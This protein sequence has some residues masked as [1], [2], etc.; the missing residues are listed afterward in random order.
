LHDQYK[1]RRAEGESDGKKLRDLFSEVF[2]PDEV[3]ILAE[4]IFHHLPAMKNE[5]WFIVEEKKTGTLVSAFALIPWKWELEGIELEV[6]EM[7]IVGT[8][9][10]HRGRGLMRDLNREFDKTLE[11]DGFDLVVIQGIPGFYDQFGFSYSIPLENHINVP[12]HGIPEKKEEDGYAFHLA[13]IK[14]IPLLM[15]E[16][17]AYRNRFSLSSIRDEA[18]WNYMLTES[19]KT[20]YG[21]EYWIFDHEKKGEAGYFRIPKQGFGTGLI[22]SEASENTTFD[23]LNSLLAFC[24]QK[25]EERD[26]PYIRLNLHN[27]SNVGKMAISMGSK[28]GTPYGWQVKFPDVARFLMKMKPVFEKRIQS[29]GFDRFS[30]AFVLDFYKS[31][32]VLHWKEGVLE[33]VTSGREESPHTLSIN[34]DLFPALCLGHRTWQEIRHCRPDIF[35]NSKSSALLTDVLFPSTMSWIYEQY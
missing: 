33:A 28:P 17:E 19:L 25:A 2:H 23:G 1:T 34:A 15:R 6:A 26:K 13:G 35:P 3:G 29:S 21:S 5:Y 4:T 18:Q 14:D 8:L 24:K 27:D 30:G 10:K 20:E 11:E 12:F 7:G 9:E 32:V 16:D 31:S 22:V